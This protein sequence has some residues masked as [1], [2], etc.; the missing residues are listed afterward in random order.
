M[1]YVKH[2]LTVTIEHRGSGG[3]LKHGR[4]LEKIIGISHADEWG[5]TTNGENG[6]FLL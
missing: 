2:P 3:C 5:V 1:K 4:T 6:L